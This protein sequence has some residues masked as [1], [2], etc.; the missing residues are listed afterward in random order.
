[1]LIEAHVI[2]AGQ[3]GRPLPRRLGLPIAPLVDMDFAL[4]VHGVCRLLKPDGLPVLARLLHL[5][6]ARA[7][8]LLQLLLDAICAVEVALLHDVLVGPQS[9]IRWRAALVLRGQL[10][11]GHCQSGE[12]V[13]LLRI[14][15]RHLTLPQLPALVGRRVHDKDSSVPR[16]LDVC[17]DAVRLV[18]DD[19]ADLVGLGR[20]EE[21]VRRVLE[22]ADVA[23]RVVGDRHGAVLV[24]PQL[25]DDDVVNRRGHLC[26][27]VVVRV[28][29]ERHVVDTRRDDL[30]LVA[31]ELAVHGK[32]LVKDPPTAFGVQ[33]A[34]G[35][36]VADL[37]E[38]R[39]EPEV[40]GSV[41]LE[42]LSQERVEGLVDAQSD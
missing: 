42:C 21:R 12:T 33:R 24:R 36:V 38:D 4:W 25:A 3:D 16:A 23:G 14:C 29:R 11:E 13:H 18:L 15:R 8:G 35:R 20:R 17:A 19:A 1:M 31:P 9:R 26:P 2:D 6:P 41:Q 22:R 34:D 37:L 39:L 30:H 5:L 10:V 32:L 28:V 40:F 7:L 27:R